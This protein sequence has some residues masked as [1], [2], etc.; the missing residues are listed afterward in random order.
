M[1]A[2]LQ[3]DAEIFQSYRKLQSTDWHV[4]RHGMAQAFLDRFMRQVRPPSSSRSMQ[5][6][7]KQQNMPE[8][9]AIPFTVHY[10]AINLSAV[11]IALYHELKLYFESCNVRV[12]RS[13]QARG[14]N[15]QSWRINEVFET[16]QS[17]EEALIK[18]CS[19]YNALPSWHTSEPLDTLV[20][21]IQRRR[22]DITALQAAVM[23]DLKRAVWLFVK[24][25]RCDQNFANLEQSVKSHDF[26]DAEVTAKASQ[27]LQEAL[28][29]YRENDWTEFWSKGKPEK[30]SKKKQ[31]EFDE[32]DESDE[33]E[34][35]PPKK[36]TKLS[37]DPG[38][39]TKKTRLPSFPEEKD[40]GKLLR[41]TAT[42]LRTKIAE[43]VNQARALRFMETVHRFQVGVNV[44]ACSRCGREHGVSGIH[45]ILGKCGHVVCN[46][47]VEAVVKAEECPVNQCRGAVSPSYIINGRYFGRH[48]DQ[49]PVSSYGGTKMKELVNLL[50]D[51]TRIP[52]E[53]RVILFVQFEEFRQR[54]Q[55]ALEANQIPYVA[56][57]ASEKNVRKKIKAFTT[58][59]NSKAEDAKVLIL[60]L[61]SENAA[62]M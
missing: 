35:L 8:I 36:K 50:Q 13:K 26:G 57:G 43:W 7:M 55:E 39:E 27:L 54:A 10:H 42:T 48:K 29:T 51:T 3:T 24:L 49:A 4:R 62:G 38:E 1:F 5:L 15:D 34:S 45:N 31:E 60:M 14:S 22:R 46:Q 28:A 20:K 12:R 18:R 17:F 37:N 44:P 19:L 41:E 47:C 9:P 40:R 11:E 58:E 25:G 30:S 6:L 61:G 56:I 32:D 23:K 53:D 59:G 2:D 16:S 21:V 52:R 33:E